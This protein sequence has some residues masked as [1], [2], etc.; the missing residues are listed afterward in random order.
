MFTTYSTMNKTRQVNTVLLQN[1]STQSSSIQPFHFLSSY[2]I[3]LDECTALWGEPCVASIAC[4]I[5]MATISSKWLQSRTAAHTSQPLFPVL[6]SFSAFGCHSRSPLLWSLSCRTAS[7][8]VLGGLP[9]CIQQLELIAR[10]VGKY[11]INFQCLSS[12]TYKW[13]QWWISNLEPGNVS[14]M[15]HSHWPLPIALTSLLHCHG[16]LLMTTPG[17]KR[18]SDAKPSSTLRF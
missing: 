14:D 5:P 18:S 2:I 17:L 1:V 10:A 16:N 15:C 7:A 3:L 9:W 11:V 6:C 8:Q 12:A 4:A 13:W